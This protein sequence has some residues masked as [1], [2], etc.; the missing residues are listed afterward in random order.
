MNIL[1]AVLFLSANVA[2]RMADERIFLD[3]DDTFNRVTCF[4]DLALFSFFA[5]VIYYFSLVWYFSSSY[6]V[7]CFALD[8]KTPTLWFLWNF[9]ISFSL[10][11]IFNLKSLYTLFPKIKKRIDTD[12]DDDSND[13]KFW[14][15]HHQR[16][17]EK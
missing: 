13:G 11:L 4:R 8:E 3:F 2:L 17:E 9:L 1:F 15:K 14:C 16:W 12:K 7:S 10:I 5:Y 6:L